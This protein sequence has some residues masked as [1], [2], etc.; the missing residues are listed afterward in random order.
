M[1]SLPLP[2]IAL[3]LSAAPLARADEG[4]WPFNM[5]P[6]ERIEQAHH[7]LLADAWLDHVRLA[8]VRFTVGGSGSFVSPRG[9]V[10]T[11]HHVGGD[12]IAKRA[13]PA[14]DYLATGYLAGRDGPEVACPDLELDNLVSTEDVT[15]RVH[16]A[17]K[18]GMSD[19]EANRAMKGAMGAIEKECH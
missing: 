10:L 4:M 1:R 17:R 15:R 8:S 3:A 12:C 2:L 6:R 7:V 11:N 16:D 19:A 5:V 18:P 9:L 13:S 14:R